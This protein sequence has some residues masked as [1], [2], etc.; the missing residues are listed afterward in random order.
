MTE[1]TGQC[2]QCKGYDPSLHSNQSLR[3]SMNSHWKLVVAL[4]QPKHLNAI[5]LK[6]TKENRLNCFSN[7]EYS[8]FAP[9]FGLSLYNTMT[10]PRVRFIQCWSG[11][12]VGFR[13]Q[14]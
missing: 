12:Y 11:I 2:L 10:I 1:N 5:N 3:V 7:A 14:G 6:S 9:L 13:D 4:M 8:T